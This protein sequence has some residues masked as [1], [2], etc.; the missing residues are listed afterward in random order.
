MC[1][2]LSELRTAECFQ[3]LLTAPRSSSLREQGAGS[4][5]NNKQMLTLH[6]ADQLSITHTITILLYCQCTKSSKDL[7]LETQ[8]VVSR[9]QT[10]AE[11]QSKNIPQS[12]VVN[13]RLCFISWGQ[14]FSLCQG[15]TECIEVTAGTLREWGRR[16]KEKIIPSGKR[17]LQLHSLLEPLIPSTYCLLQKS[18]NCVILAI[19]GLLA[20]PLLPWHSVFI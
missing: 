18:G 5:R 16:K 9:T 15:G 17:S 20:P 6:C 1:G 4:C 7:G 2:H 8:L 11:T 10:I 3:F 12:A 13:L 14:G 19:A